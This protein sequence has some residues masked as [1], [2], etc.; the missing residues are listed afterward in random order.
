MKWVFMFLSGMMV[1]L[2]IALGIVISFPD[3]PIY[4]R[5]LI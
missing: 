2:A 4:F 1:G 5:Y 3:L